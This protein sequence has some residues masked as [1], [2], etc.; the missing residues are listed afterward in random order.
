MAQLEDA[1]AVI[2]NAFGFPII[3]APA[4]EWATLVTALNQL[5]KLNELVSG[6]E[7]KLLVTLDMD[8]YKRALKMEHLEPQY[9]GKWL[10]CPGAFHTVLRAL[11]CLGRTIEGSALDEAWQEADLYSSVTTSQIINGTHYNR[12]MQAHQITLQALFYLW[13]EAFFEENP[14]QRISLQTIVEKL[15]E[16]CRAQKDV[17]Q[18]HRTFL[19]ELEAM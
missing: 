17:Y 16:A 19:F 14:S 3:N 7:A 9:K 4:H 5:T 8:L 11:R 10:L 6:P 15:T 12:A 13:I 18:A 2:D 1:P